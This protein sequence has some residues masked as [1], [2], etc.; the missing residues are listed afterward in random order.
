MQRILIGLAGLVGVVVLV[1]GFWYFRPWSDLSPSD[2][3]RLR[4]L[5]ERVEVYREMERI[6][7][8]RRIEG[9]ANIYEF[10]ENLMPLDLTYEWEGQAKSLDTYIEERTVTSLV[11][12]KDGELVFE[13]YYLDANREDRMTSW[14]VAKSYVATLINIAVEEGKISSLDDTVD[15][16]VPDFE[17]TDYGKATLRHLLMM[18]SGIGFNEDYEVEGS[19]IRKLFFN[20]FLFNA[21]VDKMVRQY[22]QDRAPGQDLD[23]ISPNTHVLSAVVRHV[24]DKPVAEIADEK[25]FKPLGSAYAYWN[26]DRKGEKGKAIG[27]CCLSVRPVDYA[28]F[29]QMYLQ[30]G[31]WN[32]KQIVSKEW[33]DTVATPQADF[34]DP[35]RNSTYG[36]FGYSYQFW[37]PP[38]YDDEFYAAG[39]NGQFIWVDRKRG[40]VIVR[41]AADRNYGG[42]SHENIAVMRAIAREVS[43][44]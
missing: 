26:Q 31:E 42:Q 15:M 32:G 19:D 40:V 5:E 20:V 36:D 33:V 9:A 39:Y 43:G 17:G 13:D 16:Y 21:D 12:L 4:N 27:Y 23:Y 2:V 1:A 25:I 44:E 35:K 34:Q 30:N 14:S 11:V 29:G 22:K 37:I 38:D 41:T 18:S 24:Y 10:P 3:I 7:P 28:K 6:L 8:S